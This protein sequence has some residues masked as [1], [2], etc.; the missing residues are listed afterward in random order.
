MGSRPS[1]VEKARVASYRKFRE[2]FRANGK[3]GLEEGLCKRAYNVAY[4]AIY[5]FDCPDISTFV[6]KYIKE[7]VDSDPPLGSLIRLQKKLYWVKLDKNGLYYHGID[8][9]VR[10][11][12]AEGD[13]PELFFTS[14]EWQ[15]MM[16]V[17]CK[18]KCI[19][20]VQS[21]AGG[22]VWPKEKWLDTRALFYPEWKILVESIEDYDPTLLRGLVEY[23]AL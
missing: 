3:F 11:W 4:D 8:D 19:S 20:I 21:R 16:L 23:S 12:H 15:K 22:L 7:R 10:Y 13:V 6:V 1:I 2:W 14:D 5:R 9:T 17:V 18:I